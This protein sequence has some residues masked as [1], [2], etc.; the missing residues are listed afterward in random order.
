MQKITHQ[1][2]SVYSVIYLIA[3]LFE[4]AG[5]YGL[6]VLLVVYL[7]SELLLNGGTESLSYPVVLSIYGIFISTLIGTQFLGGLLGDLVFKNK[8][9][10]ILGGI[11]QAIGAFILC[12]PS[13]TAVYIGL[14]FITIG[15]GLYRPNI[16]AYF[17]KL[18]TNNTK[19][20]DAA[21]T[22][23]YGFINLGAFIG[24][25]LLGYIGEIYGWMYG[26]G[27]AGVFFLISIVLPLLSKEK[28]VKN[29]DLKQFALNHRILKIVLVILVVGLFWALF[30]IGYLKRIESQ[31]SL[32]K[33][34]SFENLDSIFQQLESFFMIP[35]V[36]VFA[37]LWSWY[38]N[39]QF[40]K[41]AI[42]FIFAVASYG[43]LFLIPEVVTIYHFWLFIFSL[44]LLTLAEIHI[45][46][47]LYATLAKYGNPKY[48]AT[49]IAS[50]LVLTRLFF[51]MHQLFSDE[52]YE[53][54]SFTLKIA[55]GGMF[56][57][58]VI[59]SAGVILGR[60]YLKSNA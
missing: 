48:L 30:E 57:F 45:A 38:Y 41:L 14:G 35:V 53:D 29:K 26:F 16:M 11:L 50:S 4:R 56:I 59:L 22:I 49:L 17:G 43:I 25:L 44:F 52:I 18:Y 46:P 47:I 42:G 8:N 27:L 33:V 5:Y 54:S 51:A 1:K 21:Y 15:T 2:H 24:V 36:I 58:A 60:K 31:I 39:H 3:T 34:V 32:S 13:I 6:R 55:F 20:L 23:H 10:I 19:L 37:I 7:T 28:I 12:I 40:V 9:A